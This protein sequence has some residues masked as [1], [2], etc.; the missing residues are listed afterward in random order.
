MFELFAYGR[1]NVRSRD[2]EV[3]L[4]THMDADNTPHSTDPNGHKT[5]EIPRQ[6]DKTRHQVT[7]NTKPP[8]LRRHLRPDD[9]LQTARHRL[10][11][12]VCDSVLIEWRSALLRCCHHLGLQ[13][14]WRTCTCCTL[15][16]GR[17]WHTGLALR[18][19]RQNLGFPSQ[20]SRNSDR[21]TSAQKRLHQQKTT[22]LS[23][24]TCRNNT[25]KELLNMARPGRR[26]ERT[27]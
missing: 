19:E 11:D 6:I 3:S 15:P 10:E 20:R 8:H 27:E 7:Q 17:R 24:T 23:H 2:G 4:R 1:C 14:V 21:D 9:A 26:L 16:V 5:Q 18:G 13:C 22:S 25:Q 12:L